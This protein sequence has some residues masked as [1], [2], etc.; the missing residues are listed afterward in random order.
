MATFSKMFRI[1]SKSK[2]KYVPSLSYTSKTSW[3]S[4]KWARYAAK[5]LL[6]SRNYTLGD[7]EIHEFPIATEP[8]AKHEI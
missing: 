6:K 1:W 4:L 7:L 8:S 2:E 3:K 5:E